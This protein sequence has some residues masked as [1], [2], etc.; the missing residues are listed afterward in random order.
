MQV[1]QAINRILGTGHLRRSSGNRPSVR[2]SLHLVIW[3]LMMVSQKSQNELFVY[4]P[5]TQNIKVKMIFGFS[6]Y[7]TLLWVALVIYFRWDTQD[8]TDKFT[9]R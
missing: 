3:H 5:K 9:R 7:T 1:W 2:Y 4:Y 8:M 6:L